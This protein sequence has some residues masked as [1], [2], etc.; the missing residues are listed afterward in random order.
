[1]FY[2]EQLNF[3]N[4]TLEK[5]NITCRTLNAKEKITQSAV[6]GLLGKYSKNKCFYDFFP[7]IKAKTVYY[8][9]DIFLCRY[10]FLLLPNA[11]DNVF[12]IG[13]Y[14]NFN[15]TQ[16]QV[17]EQSEALGLSP[18]GAKE[19]EYF[20]A[21]VPVV[22]E[23]N[24]I[25]AI[26][27]TFA[28]F[29]WGTNN[30]E[31]IEIDRGEWTSYILPEL[32]DKF[33]ESN[34]QINL[35]I[36]EKRYAYENELMAAVSQGNLQKAE[37]MMSNFSLIAF[38]NRVP[39]RLRNIKNYC[40]IMNTLFRKAAQNGGVHPVYLDKTSSELAKKIEGLQSL[41]EVTELMPEILRRYCRLVKHHSVKN[42]SPLVQKAVILIDGDIN[43]DLS[44]SE[45]ARKNNVSPS[46]FSA[47]FKKETGYT[48]IEYVNSKRVDYAKYLLKNTNLQVQTIAQ[49]CGILDFHYFCR[50]FKKFTG[51]T[52]TE[53][54][55]EII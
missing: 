30:F 27:N 20:Y 47:L 43:G 49:H 23:E 13:P 19:L 14:I 33:N 25:F 52:P 12:I 32:T 8:F 48:L 34:T 35:D 50:I 36:M 28:E 24:H 1:M 10:I 2:D 21:S 41:A 53:F 42:Y 16:Q 37:L 31:N 29:I 39:D 3:L 7:Y 15:I 22:S 45:I 9:A 44:L 54:K 40:I 5:C 11:P 18:A 6:E 51:K 55:R 38:E 26:I 17:L 46:Y 4:K